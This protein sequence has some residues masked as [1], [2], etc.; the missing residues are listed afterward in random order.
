LVFMGNYR[1]KQA[2]RTPFQARVGVCRDPSAEDHRDLVRVTDRAV[3]VEEAFVQAVQRRAA[4][5]DQVGAIL[6]L[7]DEQA[8]AEPLVA[9][10]PVGEEGD[11][12]GE[13]AVAAGL[14]VR[15]RELVGQFLQ[16][17]RVGAGPEGV[18]ALLKG[19]ALLA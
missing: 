13:P 7:A 19:D 9:A 4:L 6:D 10:F 8:V 11:Q 17:C 15:R 16:P 1:A 18:G 3:Q 2:F 5:E 12:L 14:D